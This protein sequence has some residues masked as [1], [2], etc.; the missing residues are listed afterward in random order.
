MF[1]KR[2]SL[3]GLCD[4]SFTGASLLVLG[5]SNHF[6][7]PQPKAFIEPAVVMRAAAG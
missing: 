3:S 6:D 7:Q 2:I 1:K 4:W 5:V